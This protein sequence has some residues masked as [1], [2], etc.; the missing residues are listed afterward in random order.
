MALSSAIVQRMS[1]RSARV[2]ADDG[3]ADRSPDRVQRVVFALALAG[4][5]LLPLGIGVILLGWYG[6]AHT[7]YTFE[8]NAYLVSGGLLGVG[9]VLVGGFLYVGAWVAR[10]ADGQREQNARLLAALEGLR[11]PA[12]GALTG[13]PA[14][15]SAGL[16]AATTFVA[17]PT[18]T[19][20][21][22]PDCT[23]VAGRDNVRQVDDD[24][25]LRSCRLCD[26]R[27]DEHRG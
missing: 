6:V 15:A 22:R 26:P 13:R 11:L 1:P 19:M 24:P 10:L 7:P 5:V 3:A 12:D 2:R 23:I 4:A 27:G 18:G 21:H 20:L 14:A 8:Q 25:G 17:T 9:L 16:P